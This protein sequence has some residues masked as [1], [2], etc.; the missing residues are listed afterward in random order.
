MLDMRTYRG[1]NTYNRQ[2]SPGPETVFLGSQ[3]LA[4]LKQSLQNSKATWKVIASDMPVGLVVRDGKTAFEN[5]ANGYGIPLGRELEIADLLRFIKTQNIAN[6]VWLTAD[7]HYAAAHYYDPNKA[8][9]QDFEP[10]WE[11]V[12]GPLNAGT[13]GPNAL[14]NTFGPQVV[15]NSI[16]A[17]MKPKRPPSDGFQFFGSVRV[18][19][20]TEVMTVGL[21]N[22]EG[23]KIYSTDLEPILTTS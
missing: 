22:L 7:V 9:F 5:L 14:D 11:F 4:W 6:V 15:F 12:A 16:P 1:P 19:S 10:F 3:Q 20:Q 18:D 2:P 8:Q 23:T 21:Y 13:Y 17:D